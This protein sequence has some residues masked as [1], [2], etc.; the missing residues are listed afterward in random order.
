MTRPMTVYVTD[1]SGELVP[2]ELG[3]DEFP[4]K[5]TVFCDEC[6]TEVT[7]DYVINEDMTKAERLEVARA[8][9]RREG[10]RCDAFGDHCPACTGVALEKILHA[11]GP[12]LGIVL[13]DAGGGR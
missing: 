13:P 2:R 8:S 3:P 4:S 1:E 5:I 9:L 12:K 6:H 11:C 7:R 10:W